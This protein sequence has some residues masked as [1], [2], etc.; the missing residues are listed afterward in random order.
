M[1]TD[2]N[3]VVLGGGTGSFTVLSSLRDHAK[4]L[5]ALVNMADDG[6]STGVLR[7]EL[8]VLPPGDV[9][10]CLVALSDAPVALRELFNFRFQDGSLSGHSF[11]NLFLSAVEKMTEGDFGEAVRLAG[12][13][14]HIQ[15]KVIPATLDDVRLAIRWGREV[16]RG[17]G[18]IDVMDFDSRIG[19]RPELFLEPDAT[20]NPAAVHAIRDADVIIVSPG[21]LYTS[22]G[23]LLSIQ[24]IGE[25]LNETKAKI[26]YICN[27]VVKPGQTKG[28]TVHDHVEEIERIAHYPFIDHVL[29]NT[30]TPSGEVLKHYDDAGESLVQLGKDSDRHYKLFGRDLLAEGIAGKK[31]GDPL[32]A[33]RSLIR[34]DQEALRT[35]ILEIMTQ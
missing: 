33:H 9:R 23:P 27:L 6:G 15:G 5:T 17:E 30:G 12:E 31:A 14:L 34:H 21:D 11:G 16:V 35:A 3:I 24:G 28:F 2:E 32:A 29:Y 25:A 4:N 1:N 8:G 18:V 13:V 26:I 22:I 19:G 10:Q 20:A 7:D